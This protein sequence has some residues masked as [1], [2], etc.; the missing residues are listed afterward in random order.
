MA[1][2]KCAGYLLKESLPT[3]LE[4][5]QHWRG[6][7]DDGVADIYIGDE[8]LRE[9]AGS[10]PKWGP[11]AKFTVGEDGDRVHV[12]V[13][14]ELARNL[15]SV[16]AD[17]APDVAM[18]VALHIATAVAELHE[19][20]GSHGGLHPDFVG[21]D[22][23]GGLVIRPYL[24]GTAIPEPDPDASAQATDCLQCAALLDGLQ[25][26]RLDD[27]SV[28][29]VSR[30]LR[31]EVARR[32]IQ[33]GRAVRQSISAVLHRLSDWEAAIGEALGPGW[34]LDDT[35]W[36]VRQEEAA[37]LHVEVV[38][39]TADE[40]VVAGGLPADDRRHAGAQAATHLAGR[41]DGAG[42]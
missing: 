32:R 30:G 27:T 11:F 33:P 16:G 4:G 1:R 17:E 24:G 20:G 7:G 5:V 28:A 13:P 42:G 19:R 41:V 31:R 23:S 9:R 40:A 3:T 36:D 2:K 39:D 15:G 14:G 37:A 25:I 22:A 34:G 26:D 35:P 21:V 12:I 10:L 38:E 29:L 18:G 6:E 8:R